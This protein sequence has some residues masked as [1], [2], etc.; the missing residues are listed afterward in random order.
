MKR[1]KEMLERYHRK[2]LVLEIKTESIVSLFFMACCLGVA[3]YL[4]W[5]IMEKEDE[6]TIKFMKTKYQRR[7]GE[8]SETQ[9]FKM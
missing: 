8:D 3:G 2:Q 4:I 6:R 7:I 1:H 9:I 5:T